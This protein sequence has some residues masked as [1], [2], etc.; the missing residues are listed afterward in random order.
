MVNLWFA[1]PVSGKLV[2][3]CSVGGG[4]LVVKLVGRLVVTLCLLVVGEVVSWY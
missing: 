1:G 3:N 4:N 2:V